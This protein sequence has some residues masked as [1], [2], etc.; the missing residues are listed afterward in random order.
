MSRPVE[1]AQNRN[2]DEDLI[3]ITI[4]N[5][6]KLSQD[7]SQRGKDSE[8]LGEARKKMDKLEEENYAAATKVASLEKDMAEQGRLYDALRDEIEENQNQAESRIQDLEEE[9]S[10]KERKILEVEQQL[11]G[12]LKKDARDQ[13]RQLKKDGMRAIVE[14]NKKLLCDNATQTMQIKELTAQ[15]MN[16]KKEK[17]QHK[18]SMFLARTRIQSLEGKLDVTNLAER[19]LRRLLVKYILLSY[20]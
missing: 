4:N 12:K 9:L 3:A 10:E 15:L 1:R 19:Q 7:L 20:S 13:V 11:E 14:Q 8:L 2:E 18:R 16:M 17:S 5:L 6:Q